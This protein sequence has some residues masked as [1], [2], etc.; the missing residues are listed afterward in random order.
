MNAKQANE[1]ISRVT[2][3]AG[4][5]AMLAIIG[6]QSDSRHAVHAQ[7]PAATPAAP[8]PGAQKVPDSIGVRIRNVQLDQEHVKTNIIQLQNAYAEQNKQGL[9]DAHELDLLK[10]EALESAK[11]DPKEWTVDVD[12]LVFAK[13][14]PPAPKTETP[15]PADKK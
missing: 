9:S 12:H 1:G 15:K 2:I 6:F 3:I 5:I 7:A 10:K 8:A 14:P 13:I 4:I 11:L